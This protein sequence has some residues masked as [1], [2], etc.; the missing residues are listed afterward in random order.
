MAVPKAVLKA[1]IKARVACTQQA[2]RERGYDLLIVYGD[3]KV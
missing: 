3:S 1:E 2:M